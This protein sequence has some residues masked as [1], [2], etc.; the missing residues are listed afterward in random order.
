MRADVLAELGDGRARLGDADPVQH[1]RDALRVAQRDR[2]DERD[3]RLLLHAREPADEPEVEERDPVAG[4]DEDVPGVRIAV[5]QPVLEEL[6]ERRLDDVLRDAARDRS[7]PRAVTSRDLRPLHVVEREDRR[8]G[9]LRR[10]RA[11]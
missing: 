4:E 9:E 8:G 7:P 10:G 3:E 5:E 6:P 11:G 2:D 1:A